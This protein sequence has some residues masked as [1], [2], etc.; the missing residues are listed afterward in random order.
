MCV[1][2]HVN[3]LIRV[4]VCVCVCITAGRQTDRHTR[5]VIWTHSNCRL[6]TRAFM[7]GAFIRSLKVCTAHTRE[8]SNVR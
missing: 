6:V 4:C 8:R 7:R 1:C 5:H 2:V 3:V